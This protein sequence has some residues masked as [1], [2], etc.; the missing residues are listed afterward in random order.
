MVTFVPAVCVVFS[1]NI[2]PMIQVFPS[3]ILGASLKGEHRSRVGARSGVDHVDC[4]RRVLVGPFSFLKCPTQV[5]VANHLSSLVYDQKRYQKYRTLDTPDHQSWA[6]QCFVSIRIEV[7][8]PFVLGSRCAD[9]CFCCRVNFGVKNT[10]HRL[11]V[12]GVSALTPLPALTFV[13]AVPRVLHCL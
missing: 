12:L 4:N 7:L 8:G 2:A 9:P 1:R 6:R 11:R 5:V 10:A 13:Q 3:A